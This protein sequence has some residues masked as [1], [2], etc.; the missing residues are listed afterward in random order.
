MFD[1]GFIKWCIYGI[2]PLEITY[3]SVKC[4]LLQGE[5]HKAN[6]LRHYKPR[7]VHGRNKQNN[8]IQKQFKGLLCDLCCLGIHKSPTVQTYQIYRLTEY[9]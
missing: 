9:I 6:S 4:K 2:T 5:S 7:C 1:I 3:V 8:E